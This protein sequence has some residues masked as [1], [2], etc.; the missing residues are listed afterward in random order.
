MNRRVPW[1]IVVLVTLI[2][3]IIVSPALATGRSKPP[4]VISVVPAHERL[5]VHIRASAGSRCVLRVTAKHKSM[6]FPAIFTTKRGKAAIAWTVPANA[7]SGKWTFSV[8]C[9]VG[10]KTHSAKE[11]FLLINNGNG[12][13]ALAEPDSGKVLEGGLGGKGA[14]PCGPLAAPDQ[15]GN[16]VSFPGNPFNYYEGGS[17]VGEC[18]WY[19]AGRRP[20]LYG[21]VRHDA[22][23]WLEDAQGRVPEGNSP[24]VGA[25]AVWTYGG[26]GHGHVAYVSGV[27]G[28][29]V[30]VDESN[31]IFHTVT[32][33]R[34]VPAS[35]ISGYIYGGPAGNGPGSGGTGPAPVPGPGG[36]PSEPPSA[37]YGSMPA[38]AV[39]PSGLPTVVAQGPSNSLDAYWE[40]PDA[41]WH[42][43]LGIGAGGSTYSA[44]SIGASASGYPVIAA[45]GPSNSLYVYWE[46]SDA[47]WHGPLGIGGAGTTYSAPSVGVG[48]SGL[49]TVAVQGTSNSLDVYWETP[50]AQWHG[51]LGVGAGGS[52]YSAPSVT[53]TSTVI[54]EGPSNSLYAYW[55]TPDAQWHGPLGIGPG[56]STYSAPSAVTTGSGLPAVAVQ[57]PSNSLYA[58][59]ETPDAQWHGPLGIGPGGSTLSAPSVA[60][61]SSGLPTVGAAGPSNSLDLYW[62]TGDAQWHGPLGVGA[63]GSTFSAPSLAASPSGLPVIATQGPSNSLYAY[64]ETP[65]AQW[66]GPL[67]IGA[68]GSTF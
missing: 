20:D 8:S 60:V 67:G 2:A 30:T 19:A 9:R 45:E 3:L 26:G 49:P 42:G 12:H 68:G 35:Q 27:N 64:W 46:T 55:E 56:G 50:D 6:S 15:N 13:G 66:H 22:R 57:G 5:A 18:T 59:W 62:E 40:T 32:Y 25:I 65:D 16:C 11:K 31:Y 44:P 37:A 21:I 43:P 54:A 24:T 47:Q 48:S 1:G 14:G 63:G 29:T 61:G 38:I 39:G 10:H 53:S 52:T 33:G 51:P 41:Q 36:G 58:Y 23:Q 4:V 34:S 17:D 28:S 7:P